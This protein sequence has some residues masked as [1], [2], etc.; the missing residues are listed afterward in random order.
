MQRYAPMRAVRGARYWQAVSCY[1]RGGRYWVLTR[2]MFLRTQYTM[3]GTD[4]TTLNPEPHTLNPP[5]P[6]N[7]K[8]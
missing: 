5:N 4:K 3:S 6:P 8:P 2:R 7:P 1:A